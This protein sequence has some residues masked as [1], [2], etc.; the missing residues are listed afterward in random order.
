[1]SCLPF[2]ASK[3]ESISSFS[4]LQRLPASLRSWAC[5]RLQ[6]LRY[7]PHLFSYSDSP[8][9]LLERAL[10]LHQAHTDNPGLSPDPLLYSC[11]VYFSMEG[12]KFNRWGCGCLWGTII[13]P[14]R[15]VFLFCTV[16][17]LGNYLVSHSLVTDSI[18]KLYIKRN[19]CSFI[20]IR[21]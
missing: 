13:L 10:W 7:H 2:G 16:C 11:K 5:L 8:A 15:C 9:S 19:I 4:S 12:R 21:H 14:I 17:L 18:P 3:E 20:S 6:S 1:M